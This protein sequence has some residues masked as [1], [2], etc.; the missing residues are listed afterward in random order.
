MKIALVAS[1]GGHL[2]EVRALRPV[3]ERHEHFYVLNDRAL[4]SKDMEGKTFFIRHSERDWLFF[5]NLWEAWRVLR[6][7]RPHLILSTGAGP[8]VPFALVGKLL[9]IPTIYI[10]ISTT[11]TRPSISGRIMYHLADKFFYQW[12]GLKPYFP[13]GIY[14]GL[15][16]WSS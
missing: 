12:E 7:E 4:L 9:R 16:Q 5:V 14:G 3:Y 13:K 8:V 2:A 15:L 1:C 6:R 11:V 10:E